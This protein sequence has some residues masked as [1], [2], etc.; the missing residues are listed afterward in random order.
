MPQALAAHQWTIY[1]FFLLIIFFLLLPRACRY[2][3]LLVW[4]KPRLHL[5]SEGNLLSRNCAQEC[6]AIKRLTMKSTL[7]GES[8]VGAK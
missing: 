8:I 3:K 4:E 2:R 1:L 6:A 5:A 7:T